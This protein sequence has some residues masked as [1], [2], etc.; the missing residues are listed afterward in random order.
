MD[1]YGDLEMG[2]HD[3]LEMSGYGNSAVGYFPSDNIN[4]WENQSIGKYRSRNIGG[5]VY[6]HFAFTPLVLLYPDEYNVKNCFCTDPNMFYNVNPESITCLGGSLDTCGAYYPE[7]L[8]RH[9]HT[10]DK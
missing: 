3:D 2:G 6:N 8:C 9:C 1:G 4:M 7:I 5:N 10:T